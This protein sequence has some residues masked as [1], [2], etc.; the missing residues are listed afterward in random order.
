LPRLA[1]RAPGFAKQND[2]GFGGVNEASEMV[3]FQSE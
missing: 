2:A 3:P 1:Y